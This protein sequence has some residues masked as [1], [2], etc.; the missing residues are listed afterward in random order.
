MFAANIMPNL[1]N[2]LATLKEKFIIEDCS[3]Q[4]LGRFLK[5]H[6]FRYKI[7]NKRQAIMESARL[8]KW[9][10]EYI[11]KI[12]ECRNKGQDIYYLDETWFD[13]HD[14]TRRAWTDDSMKSRVNVP[15]NRGKRICIL[16]CGGS[17]GWVNDALLLTSKYIKD[18]SLDYHQDI[19]ST[20]FESWFEETLLPKIK[21]N[22]VIVLDN[23][24]Y[25]SRQTKKIPTKYSNKATIQE[26]LE[27]EDLYYEE[28]YTKAQLVEVLQLKIMT[29]QYFIDETAV[30]NGHTV[31]RL[32]P[33]YCVLNP[34]ELLWSQLKC[35]V[36]KHNT[37][38]KSAGSVITLIQEEFN[39]ISAENWKN[40][41]DHVIKIE[42]EY[43]RNVPVLQKI[44]INVNDT[45]SESE[46][47]S[48]LE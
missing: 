39:N 17:N 36:R 1:N 46:G 16:H 25:H 32:P 35:N 43:M 29:K 21:P 22:S 26:F 45:D 42:K 4:T 6:G 23:A 9:R 18:S 20:I 7:V 33:Y 41:I 8:I 37:C 2:L 44:I 31:L 5:Q 11:E 27:A 15:H 28:H 19:E 40:A 48:D 10:N 30:K 38:P 3:T 12:T 34:I 13:S 24:S 14:T 47:D